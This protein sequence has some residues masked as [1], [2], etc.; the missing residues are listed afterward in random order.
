MGMGHNEGL[1]G[2]AQCVDHCVANA[3]VES[4]GPA[5]A[6]GWFIEKQS[7]VNI[8]LNWQCDSYLFFFFLLFTPA[9]SGPR[10]QGG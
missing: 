6:S 5:G 1:S 3:T 9:F 4:R 10:L 2:S 7:F 8:N